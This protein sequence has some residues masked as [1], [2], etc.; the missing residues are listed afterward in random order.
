MRC[1]K[2]IK[3]VVAILSLLF[4]ISIKRRFA[5]LVLCDLLLLWLCFDI[6]VN[7]NRHSWPDRFLCSLTQ[8]NII[9]NYVIIQRRASYIIGAVYDNRRAPII[10]ITNI[11][12]NN[13]ESLSGCWWFWFKRI[14]GATSER[15]PVIV[16]SFMKLLIYFHI[17]ISSP[18]HAWCDADTILTRMNCSVSFEEALRRRSLAKWTFS[19]CLAPATNKA[20]RPTS[21]MPRSYAIFMRA[22]S[23]IELYYWQNASRTEQWR[24]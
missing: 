8:R 2:T 24:N 18:F 6:H 10:T 15:L 12:W 7:R 21:E 16:L 9:M 11:Q 20:Q 23:N 1:Y 13:Q 17:E 3:L 4:A 5:R 22:S 14:N 19:H